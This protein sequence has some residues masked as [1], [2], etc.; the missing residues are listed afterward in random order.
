[1]LY[2]GVR[3]FAYTSCVLRFAFFF[4]FL[5]R[6]RCTPV[7]GGKTREIGVG[8][9]PELEKGLLYVS[10]RPLCFFLCVCAL[11]GVRPD[12]GANRR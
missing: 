5:T 6:G 3:C 10:A 4:C 7:F 12:V 1:M 8:K 11:R 9:C 2:I